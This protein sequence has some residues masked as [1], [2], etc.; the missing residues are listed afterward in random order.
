[1]ERGG[2]GS[3]MKSTSLATPEWLTRVLRAS[4]CLIQGEVVDVAA[5]VAES[6]TSE[7]GHLEVRYSADAPVSAPAR[8]FLK[9]RNPAS[10]QRVVGSD[11]WRWEVEFHTRIASRMRDPPVVPCC[12]AAFCETTG[13]AHLLLLDV[14]ATHVQP[15]NPLPPSRMQCERAL[16]AFAQVHAFW[17]DHADL[18]EIDELPSEESTARYVASIRECFPG[19]ADSLGDAL[20]S[21]RRSIY[22][23]VLGELPRLYERTSSAS[24]LTLIHGD[25]HWQ[26]VLLPRDPVAGRAYI[27][28]WQLWGISFAAEDL[29]NL[30][31]LQW[32]PE[33]RAAMERELLG[34]YHR[35]LVRGGVVGY[36]WA[37]C[38]ND[39]RLA[40]VTRALFMPMWQWSSGQPPRAWW[41]N[42]ECALQAFDDLHCVEL[43]KR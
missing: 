35:G 23:R 42:L 19:F 34:C 32:Y 10:G 16:E 14:S 7:I 22:A 15:A 5:S 30:I 41:A 28:D 25:A 33:Q 1:M 11:Q 27:V 31:A 40:V 36:T 2:S 26:N 8:L 12:D 43:L 24:D 4:G 29:A 21:A 17:W 6:F 13:E 20:S 3:Q 18:G 38:W 9:V 37:D 39:Y